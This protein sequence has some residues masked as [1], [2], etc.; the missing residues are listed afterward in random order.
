MFSCSRNAQVN[1]VEEPQLKI[2]SFLNYKHQKSI[3]TVVN[4]ALSSVPRLKPSENHLISQ[5]DILRET[6][7]SLKL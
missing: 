5:S 1:F 3:N 7:Y 6:D 4:R 2:I